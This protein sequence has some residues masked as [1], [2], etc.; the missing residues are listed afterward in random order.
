MYHNQLRD[1]LKKY[2]EGN[3][4]ESE[5]ALIETWYVRNYPTTSFNPSQDEL[6]QDL[7]TITAR[8]PGSGSIK[9]KQRRKYLQYASIAA[10][11]LMV[12]TITLYFYKNIDHKKE[13]KTVKVTQEIRPGGNKATLTLS[14]G[15][16]ILV[17]KLKHGTVTQ[18]GRVTIIKAKN[19]QLIYNI[20]KAD[21]ESHKEAT[22]ENTIT[23]PRGGQFQVNLPDGTRVWL[24]AASTL[25]FPIVFK[26]SER[27]VRLDGEAYFEVSKDVS[28]PFRVQSGSQVVEVLGTHFNINAYVDELFIKTTLLEGSV[29]ISLLGSSNARI[30]KPGQESNVGKTGTVAVKQADLEQA[31]SWKNG[32]FV[33]TGDNIESIMRKLS[34]WYNVDIEFRGDM[35]GKN[36]V[37]T[38]FRYQTIQ[39][40]LKALELTG[41]VHFE[42]T[43]SPNGKERRLIVMP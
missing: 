3:C 19:G 39:D 42:I 11:L 43:E 37:G 7:A 2:T 35:S 8:L 1:L 38:V 15:T 30:L 16:K 20:L 17:D 33:F 29:R 31:V 41:T 34:R 32:K 24:N 18:Q 40:V 25:T 12:L 23:T 13:T 27:T 21:K 14:D 9:L 10:S 22:G 26:N 36:F 4:T 6:E 28:R 5:K